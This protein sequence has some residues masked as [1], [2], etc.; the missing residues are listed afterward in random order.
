MSNRYSRGV[1]AHPAMQGVTDKQTAVGR[2][3]PPILAGAAAAVSGTGV[4]LA[5]TDSPSALRAP[6]VLFFLFA[7]P[8]AGLYAVLR[9]L[10]PS[11]RLV[12]AAAG[13]VAADLTVA[14]A[15]S[16]L[17][18]L[19][20]TAGVTAIVVV[21]ALLF[22]CA[23]GRRGNTRSHSATGQDGTGRDLRGTEE[24]ERTGPFR[25]PVM[26]IKKI[27]VGRSHN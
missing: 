4:A 22:L 10:R 1:G 18:A 2:D 21:T 6:F 15:L 27:R 25:G 19:T 7:G 9:N 3:L 5:L 16:G 11:A 23:V 17:E 24:S 20:V 13:A 26:K 12:T 14:A 8:A